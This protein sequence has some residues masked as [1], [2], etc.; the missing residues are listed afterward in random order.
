MSIQL[1]DIK[2]GLSLVLLGLAFGVV[3]GICFGVNEDLF[4]DFIAQGV[5]ANPDVHDANSPDKIWRYAQRAHFHATGMAAFSIGLVL[6]VSASS[7]SQ[8]LKKITSTLIGLGLLY[9]L[10]WLSMFFLAPS[11]GRDVAHSHV[12]TALFTYTGIGCFAAGFL[13]LVSNIFIGTLQ[14]DGNT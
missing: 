11:L 6:L 10:A 3:L 9:P 13:I 2:P 14:S 5:A 1:A 8:K 12:L 7:L 4:K